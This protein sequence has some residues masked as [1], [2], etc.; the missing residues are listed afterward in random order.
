M[1]IRHANGDINSEH[2]RDSVNSSASLGL[3]GVRATPLSR[4]KANI[5]VQTAVCCPGRLSHT[6]LLTV[7]LALTR[8]S[9]AVIIGVNCIG[10][11][12]GC[13][14][15]LQRRELHVGNEEVAILVRDDLHATPPTAKKLKRFM[16][17]PF[18]PDQ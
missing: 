18:V 1:S 12:G 13:K 16:I 3:E 4:V 9:G 7:K 10:T 5:T 8:K 2:R 14:V 6:A 17:L 11:I 15:D